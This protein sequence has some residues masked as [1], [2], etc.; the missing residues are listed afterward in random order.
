MVEWGCFEVV[1]L[2]L[3]W[4]F[5]EN[6]FDSEGMLVV[7]WLW[8]CEDVFLWERERRFFSVVWC[9]YVCSE[10]F[11]SVSQSVSGCVCWSEGVCQC[12]VMLKKKCMLKIII[13]RLVKNKCSTKK[14]RIFLKLLN[15]LFKIKWK[16]NFYKKYRIKNKKKITKKAI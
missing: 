10:Y 3:L 4:F 2:V 8:W 13:L 14:K 9:S 1:R 6:F 5:F 11:L 16:K 15:Y 12:I 7:F